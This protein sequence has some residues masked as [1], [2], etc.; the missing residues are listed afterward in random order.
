MGAPARAIAV[1]Q[2]AIGLPSNALGVAQQGQRHGALPLQG[3]GG[4]LLA[5]EAAF[6]ETDL[7]L[8]AHWCEAW[9]HAASALERP[10]WGR[11]LRDPAKPRR[12]W[13][14]PAVRGPMSVERR[15]RFRSA[16][17]RLRRQPP[18]RAQQSAPD[19]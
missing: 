5:R 14:W 9:Q 7:T 19:R 12:R 13:L 10:A 16:R 18:V 17:R 4:L 2:P 15:H 11:R 6:S 8:L 1:A 3:G